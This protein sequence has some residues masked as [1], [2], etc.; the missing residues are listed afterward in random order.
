[1]E[2]Y[3]VDRPLHE[4][5]LYQLAMKDRTS[6]EIMVAGMIVML[7]LIA[8]RFSDSQLWLRSEWEISRMGADGRLSVD[9]FLKDLQRHMKSGPVTILEIAQ[10]LYNEYIIRQHQAVATTKLPDNTFRF[11]RQGDRLRFHNLPNSLGFM[12]SRFDSIS[13]TIHELGFCGDLNS[14]EHELTEDGRRLLEKG[15]L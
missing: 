2:A 3:Y 1:L 4:H 7:A 8:L 10:W 13:T 12:N 9:G 11:Q 14:P 6:P 15:D 5:L